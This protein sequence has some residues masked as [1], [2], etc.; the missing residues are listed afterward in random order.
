[1]MEGKMVDVDPSKIVHRD[2]SR[3]Y[4]MGDLSY[5]L[6]LRDRGFSETSPS[7]SEM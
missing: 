6:L 2:N 4:I 5:R 1:M 7:V 3:V